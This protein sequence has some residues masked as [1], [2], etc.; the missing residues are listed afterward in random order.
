MKIYA[1]GTIKKGDD[2]QETVNSLKTQ[3]VKLNKI[4][5]TVD[6][7]SRKEIVTAKN[8]IVVKKPNIQWDNL[9][10]YIHSRNKHIN[11]LVCATEKLIKM[12]YFRYTLSQNN[13]LEIK[14]GKFS[15]KRRN[16][17]LNKI[18]NDALK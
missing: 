17:Q 7:V 9:H 5:I 15:S 12:G 10:P 6:G 2:L 3:T 14:E 4:I 1:C 13:L 16:E 8:G 18:Y 11:E